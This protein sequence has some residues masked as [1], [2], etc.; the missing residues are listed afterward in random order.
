MSR[1]SKPWLLED[2]LKMLYLSLHGWKG[3]GH[4]LE[5][6]GQLMGRKPN[7]VKIR[8]MFYDRLAA[9]GNWPTHDTMQ[10]KICYAIYHGYTKEALRSVAFDT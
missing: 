10:I 9:G 1:K 6:I 8:R 2:D 4:T 5:T 7:A 3:T